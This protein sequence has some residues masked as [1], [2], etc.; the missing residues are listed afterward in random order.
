M[1]SWNFNKLPKEKFNE[2]IKAF[3]E[4]DIDILVKLHNDYKLSS[5]NYC[6]SPDDDMITWFGYAIEKNLIY[7]I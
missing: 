1:E 2:A 3:N 4:V 6:C 7:E 5:Y